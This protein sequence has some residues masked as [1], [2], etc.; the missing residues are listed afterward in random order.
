M[1][2][3]FNFLLAGL[4]QIAHGV[5]HRLN[6]LDTAVLIGYFSSLLSLLHCYAQGHERRAKGGGGGGWRGG[7]EGEVAKENL[8]VNYS[9]TFRMMKQ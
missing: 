6:G 1:N 7:G 8:W 4:K 2:C 9:V 3:E 5:D